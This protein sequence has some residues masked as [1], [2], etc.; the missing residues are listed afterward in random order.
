VQHIA[1]GQLDELSR[2]GPRLLSE[3]AGLQ[4]VRDLCKHGTKKK[5]RCVEAPAEVMEVLLSNGPVPNQ[6]CEQNEGLSAW[7]F[8]L[9]EMSEQRHTADRK[10]SIWTY[11]YSWPKLVQ[12]PTLS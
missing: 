10:R 9:T 12:R 1:D 3:S 5:V 4:A 6:V 7:Q 8:A 11:R 2:E